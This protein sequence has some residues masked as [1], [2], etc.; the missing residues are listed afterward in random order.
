MKNFDE[1]LDT[2]GKR[3]FLNPF[4]TVLLILDA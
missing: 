1:V 3:M 2:L 4:L